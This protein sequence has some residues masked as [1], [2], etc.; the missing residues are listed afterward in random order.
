MGRLRD[1]SGVS[2]VVGMIFIL[3]IVITAISI[4]Y[5]G[6]Y[7]ALFR[8]RDQNYQANVDEAFRV[9]AFNIN[10]VV[11][12]EAPS[13]SIEIRMFDSSVSFLRKSTLN[14]SFWE[15]NA[16]SGQ[17]EPTFTL[18]SLMT[19][20]SERQGAKVAYE[21][22]G[23][24]NLYPGGGSAMLLEPPFVVDVNR[25]S[26][27][28]PVA[29]PLSSNGSVSGRGIARVEVERYCPSTGACIPSLRVATVYNLT[30]R[31]QSEY[32]PGWRNFLNTSLALPMD[33]SDCGDGAVRAN[34]SAR[35]GPGPAT[36]YL[37]TVNMVGG[38][39]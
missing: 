29:A 12:G 2:E 9:L 26:V 18:L 30:L 4:V 31:I 27:V 24:W 1:D 20:E 16:T 39:R 37:S 35:L 7:P 13:Q 11:S 17:N 33:D 38:V 3:G 14:I 10:R 21:G 15:P 32:C 22:G 36:L 19:V 6:G 34:I 23:I 8:A 25:S 5:A 28:I